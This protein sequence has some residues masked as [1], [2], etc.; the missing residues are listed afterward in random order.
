MTTTLRAVLKR[1]TNQLIEN[2]EM[3]QRSL[4]KISLNT[5]RD[6]ILY[7][8]QIENKILE[9]YPVKLYVHAYTVVM[10]IAQFILNCI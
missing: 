5:C 1:L 3:V 8:S 7:V 6:G 10:Q 9:L 4:F 2:E